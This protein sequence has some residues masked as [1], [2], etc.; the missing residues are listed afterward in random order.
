MPFRLASIAGDIEN[1]VREPRIGSRA[2]PVL[3]VG[4]DD[5]HH[6]GV[7]RDR[8]LTALPIQSLAGRANQLL[9]AARRRFMNM[10]MCPAT[11]LERDVDETDSSVV[12]LVQ[13]QLPVEEL[14]T[15][16]IRLADAERVALGELLEIV[17]F[18]RLPLAP[19]DIRYRIGECLL[20]IRGEID[21]LHAGYR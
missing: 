1:D 12:D 2:V 13:V 18:H 3:D 19:H 7:Q 5:D 21:V 10:P 6:T 8:F 15:C 9:P 11:R 16:G 17:Y 4:R 20:A 14:G